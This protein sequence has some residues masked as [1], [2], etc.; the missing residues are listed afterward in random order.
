MSGIITESSQVKNVLTNT[1][2]GKFFADLLYMNV[3]TSFFSGTSNLISPLKQSEYPME[4]KGASRLTYYAS[5]FPT[6]EVN[7]TFYKLPK[8][9][10]IQKWAYSV[11]GNFRFS[12]KVP[13]GV[14]HAKDLQ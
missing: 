8:A 3:Q 10:T 1:I 11:P 12:F 5:L 2:K 14:T 4:F 9:A 6:V 7:A 13:K